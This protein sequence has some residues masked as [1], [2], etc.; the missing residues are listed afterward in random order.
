MDAYLNWRML[1]NA[2]QVS[3]SR[4]TKS[5]KL[6][7]K[8]SQLCVI[9]V[10]LTSA[11]SFAGCPTPSGGCPSGQTPCCCLLQS[12]VANCSDV[13]SGACSNNYI[14]QTGTA[15]ST[16]RTLCTGSTGPNCTSGTS[17]C[18]SAN[19]CCTEP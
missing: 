14:L 6:F 2:T 1:M 18:G 17:T 10:S 15:N 11:F 8:L 9:L 13:A 19:G 7:H 3:L 4:K 16:L 12:G 5:T